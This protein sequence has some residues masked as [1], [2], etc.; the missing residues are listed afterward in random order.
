MSGIWQHIS[1]WISYKKYMIPIDAI[2]RMINGITI[3]EHSILTN[4]KYQRIM[5]ELLNHVLCEFNSK[6]SMLKLPEYIDHFVK[7]HI[8]KKQIKL[9]FKELTNNY[10]WLETMFKHPK[11]NT[12]HFSNVCQL[13]E[14][15]DQITFIMAQ[16]YIIS[17]SECVSL[18]SDITVI[19][20]MDINVI[21]RCE[22]PQQMKATNKSRI[23]EYR[24]QLQQ[25]K[26][27]PTYSTNSVTFCCDVSHPAFALLTQQST[28]CVMADNSTTK[29]VSK[30]V[31]A[32]QMTIT[33]TKK[34]VTAYIKHICPIESNLWQCYS[35][36]VLKVVWLYIKPSSQYY[37]GNGKDYIL[38][39][40]Y[41]IQRRLLLTV[42][43]YVN[44]Y[45][46]KVTLPQN[47]TDLIVYYYAKPS[48]MN[49]IIDKHH[50]KFRDYILLCPINDNN[51]NVIQSKLS[52]KAT[53]D[54]FTVKYGI[55]NQQTLSKYNFERF[56]LDENQIYVVEHLSGVPA[57]S[58][59][60]NA[61]DELNAITDISS[62][63]TNN[64]NILSASSS[65]AVDNN[66]T[67]ASSS[68]LFY[69]LH[70]YY[71]RNYPRNEMNKLRLERILF[72]DDNPNDPKNKQKQRLRKKLQLRKSK[73]RQKTVRNDHT[74]RQSHYYS[75]Y[76]YNVSI[77]Q[78]KS[79]NT[80][81]MDKWRRIFRKR[82]CNRHQ[83]NRFK[84]YP[85]RYKTYRNSKCKHKYNRW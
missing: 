15:A 58:T 7:W 75:R 31:Y 64:N 42:E 57:S 70:A 53:S 39:S 43:A 44:T 14:N 71:T 20:A 9:N 81:V 10:K 60:Q 36:D 82:A 41:S 38:H 24:Q 85:K 51:W 73:S 33:V 54:N 30:E 63:T 26:W 66:I 25:L 50:E 52:R 37:D 13:F 12:L 59:I 17:Y 79:K 45:A 2:L 56:I 72:F 21:I 61:I 83:I 22:W 84:Q 4:T 76:L 48:I 11:Q 47:I 34:I 49:I 78:N 35:P 32:V 69:W 1:R 8:S 74:N 68:I 5:Y 6:K 55:N 80:I 27:T 40:K 3:H 18:I 28:Q 46:W 19:S 62:S 23:N 65:I 29:T 16:N 67:L 77:A